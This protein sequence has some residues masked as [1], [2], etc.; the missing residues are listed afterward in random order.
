ME[1]ICNHVHNILRFLI[2]EQKWNEA[3]LLV[4]KMVYTSC[5]TNW[6]TNKGLGSWEIRKNQEKFIELYPSAQSS[7]EIEIL[8]MLAKNWWKIEIG[9]SPYCAVSHEN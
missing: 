8:S 9:I 3:R 5:F 7:P 2:L 4:I 1:M 6:R